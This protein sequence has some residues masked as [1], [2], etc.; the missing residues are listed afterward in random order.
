M[1]VVVSFLKKPAVAGALVVILLAIAGWNMFRYVSPPESKSAWPNAW[2]YDLTST[3]LF[4]LPA[5][6][7]PPVAAPGGDEAGVWAAVYAC[8]S[9]DDQ[10]KH[11]VAWLE[12]FSPETKKQLEDLIAPRLKGYTDFNPYETLNMWDNTGHLIGVPG[13]EIKWVQMY[14]TDAEKIKAEASKKCQPPQTFV[15]CQPK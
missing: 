15:R 7:V 3:K 9:C 14:S 8:G 10:S 2:Y 4:V 1:E 12:K 6:S 13:K 11:F 5:S